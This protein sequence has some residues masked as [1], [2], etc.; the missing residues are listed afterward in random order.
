MVLVQDTSLKC[1]LPYLVC[2]IFTHLTLNLIDQLLKVS[3]III[4]KYH[5]LLHAIEPDLTLNINIK[6]TST[7]SEKIFINYTA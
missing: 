1:V 5:L 7:F 2:L 6:D 4:V 3:N